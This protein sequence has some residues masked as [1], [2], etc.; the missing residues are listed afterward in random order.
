MKFDSFIHL[1]GKAATGIPVPEEVLT[2]LGAGKRPAVKVTI[3][4]FTFRSTVG[5]MNGKYNIPVSAERREK[6]RVVPGQEVEVEIEV[7][8]EPRT[9]DIPPELAAALAKDK[10]AAKVFSALSNSRKRLLVDPIEQ[11]KSEETRNRRVSFAVE[12]LKEGSI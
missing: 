12:K 6:A 4:G 5:S 9:I 3:Q 7:D 10:E 8:N 2:E 1:A 11:A